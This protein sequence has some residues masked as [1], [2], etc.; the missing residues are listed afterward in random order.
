MPNP[1]K[2]RIEIKPVPQFIPEQSDPDDGRYVFAYTIT[3]RNLGELPGTMTFAPRFSPDGSRIAF[4]S[5]RGGGDNIWV[6]NADGSDKRQLT[7]ETFRLLNNPSWSPDGQ[8]IVARKHFTTG[9]SLGTGELWL[10][11][12]SGGNGVPLVKR[13][14]EVHQKELGEPMFAPEQRFVYAFQ[15]AARGTP[16]A[17]T[18][19]LC[20]QTAASVQRTRPSV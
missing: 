7:K 20:V 19:K 1:E 5:D 6:M 18:A 16:R 15:L 9:R 3:I 11:H 13:P 12:I 2:Y 17:T 10:Y 14:S 4:T 8:Y